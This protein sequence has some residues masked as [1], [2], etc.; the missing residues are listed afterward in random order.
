[1]NTPPKL[2]ISY[3]HDND[4]HKGWVCELAARLRSDGVNVIL[5]QWEL[6]LGSNVARFM[7]TELKSAN[8]ILVICS[9]EYVKKANN[10]EGG[11]GY[12]GQ[13]LTENLIKNQNQNRV[14]PIIYSNSSSELMPSFL[15]S[16]YY[17]DFRQNENF[18][19]NY[20]TLLRDIL[21]KPENQKPDLGANPFETR[22]ETKDPIV[23]STSTEYVSKAMSGKVTFDYSNNNGRY[24]LGS[25]EML[26]ET[27]WTEAGQFSIY[28]YSDPT[29]IRSV[30]LAI[31]INEITEITDA[32]IFD[33]SSRVRNAKL[34]EIIIWQN[35]S[36]CYLATKVKNL[37]CRSRGAKADSV[38]FTY[39]I[40]PN[41]ERNF[42]AN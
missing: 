11:A 19:R 22:Q 36:G 32:S 15:T 9:E 17:A 41:K 38:T 2:F 25:G 12:E 40:Q 27:K 7:E 21:E 35:T 10:G 29:S 20:D 16:R 39:K 4:C 14:I 42:S 18:K 30:A 1:M 3:S 13:I 34:N 5:D 6:K 33:T 31:N 8:R 37:A 24:V 28:A 23:S 26:F